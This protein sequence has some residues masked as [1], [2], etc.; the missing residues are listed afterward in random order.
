MQ[1][2]GLHLGSTG[3]ITQGPAWWS[4]RVALCWSVHTGAGLGFTP[5]FWDV[6]G[7]TTK[8]LVVNLCSL[9][10]VFLGIRQWYSPSESCARI[11]YLRFRG[12]SQPCGRVDPF[13]KFCRR[14]V[15]YQLAALGT[16]WPGNVFGH[17]LPCAGSAQFE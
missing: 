9:Q 4:Q 1:R 8:C 11:V 13:Y 10:S 6:A 17:F 15:M 5:S 3:A 14:K 7:G 12:W 16:F 2:K